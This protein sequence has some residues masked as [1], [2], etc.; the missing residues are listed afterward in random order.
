MANFAYTVMDKGGNEK[1]GT[2]EAE[3]QD[4]A[5]S[6]LKNEGYIVISVAEASALNKEIKLSGGAGKKPTA[7]DFSIMCRQFESMLAAGVTV[8]DAMNML[9]SQTENNRLRV[10]LKNVQVSV[11]K[12]DTLASSMEAEGIFPPLLVKMVRAGEASGSLEISLNRM[13]TQFEKDSKT[14]ALIKKA[15]VYPI[16]VVIVAIAVVVVMLIVVIPNYVNMFDDMGVE[17]PKITQMV[18]AMSNFLIEKWY[19]VLAVGAGLVFLIKAAS[20]TDTGQYIL[21]KAG[22]TLPVLGDFTIK[23]S[24]ARFAR[25][26]STLLA[27]GIGLVD[28]VDI[29]ADTMD[30]VLVRQAMKQ[31][32]EE[33]MLGT[34]LSQPLEQS[35]MFPPMVYQMTRI[36]EES[37]DVEGL[38][39]KLADYYEEEV[40]MATQSLMA[41]MEPMIIIVLAG[42]VGFLVGAC[43]APML[44]MYQAMDSL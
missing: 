8:I 1:K 38:L 6:Q 20:K 5:T 37:G 32:R 42:I 41:A 43:M 18:V 21:G 15:M 12:G 7:R 3:N 26:L 31:C 4:K 2:I 30:N 22:L 28:A 14:Q 36:G 34:P 33:V 9:G 25:T 16:V 17:L 27:A 44:T 19:I 29:V 35:G 13:A 39:T 11:E 24:T 23:S 10:A 40:E